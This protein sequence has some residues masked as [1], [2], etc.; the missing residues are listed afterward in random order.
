[1]IIV[2]AEK[3]IDLRRAP[4]VLCVIVLLNVMV[5]FGFQSGDQKKMYEGVTAYE[6]LDYLPAEW[7]HFVAFLQEKG[8]LE[9][10]ERSEAQYKSGN[11]NQLVTTLLMREDFYAH[12]QENGRKFFVPSFID[13][14]ALER[15]LINDKI[16]SVSFVAFGLSERV[17]SVI[18]YL[19]HLFLHGDAM[20]LAGNML[21]LVVCGFAVEAAI[22][23]WRFLLFYL[24]SGVAAG[25]TY[26][27]FETGSGSSLIGASGA[28]S[29]VMAM[30][31]A[32]FRL[33]KIE[34]FYWFFCFVG[35]FK[36][37]ALLILFFYI[38]KEVY[39][40]LTDTES[41][42][43]FMAHAGGFVT[44]T[45]LIGL[46]MVIRRSV[47]DE[48]YINSDDTIDP[49]QPRLAEIYQAIEKFRFER[50]LGL[51]DELIRQEGGDFETFS[52][53]YNLH[54]I[55]RSASLPESATDLLNLSSGIPAEVK[56]LAKVWKETPEAPAGLDNQI[57]LNLG[58]R[59]IDA[60][61]VQL[62]E[63][64]YAEL[65]EKAFQDPGMRVFAGKL[66]NAFKALRDSR[67]SE[68]YAKFA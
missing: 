13:R 35:F 59:F 27:F 5:F 51:V 19:S 10:L 12:L 14:W 43:A 57:K 17:R 58:Q 15:D 46:A 11:T 16:Q 54:R 36:A 33:R 39:W 7:P 63:Q 3:R 9:L 40:Y 50:A 25:A 24:L 28:I 21:F 31:L 45:I 2:P 48:A 47:L 38:G 23:H 1:M 49:R 8:E 55:L 26:L 53:R 62:A 44:G 41:N 60:G 67:K 64:I 30:Y 66:S 52:I 42:I 34:F 4:V 32:I 68:Y 56:K 18:T 37:P 61:S 29:G 22:G 65:A 6:M 20:H